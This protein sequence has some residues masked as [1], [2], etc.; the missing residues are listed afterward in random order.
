MCQTTRIKQNGEYARGIMSKWDK[1]S[2][3]CSGVEDYFY[4][5][6]MSFS[7]TS[8]EFSIK[9]VLAGLRMVINHQTLGQLWWILSNE[10]DLSGI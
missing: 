1:L 8:T 2:S 5:C 10:T 4:M 3:A 6:I 7:N 9:L